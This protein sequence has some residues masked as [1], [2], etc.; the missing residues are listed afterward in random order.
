M[1]F[2]TSFGNKTRVS[3]TCQEVTLKPPLEKEKCKFFVE[4]E[5]VMPLA[6]AEPNELQALGS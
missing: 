4:I 5:T 6:P 1:L 2:F 3:E